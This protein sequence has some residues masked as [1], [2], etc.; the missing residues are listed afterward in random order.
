MKKIII[1]AFILAKFSFLTAQVG[2][3]KASVDGDAILDFPLSNTGIIL[4]MVDALPTA[5][6]ASNGTFLLDK[7]DFR[8][9]MRENDLWVSLSDPGSLT[10]T[11]PNSSAEAGG[12]VIIGAASSPAQGVLVLESASKALVLPKVNDP[13]TSMK[14]PVAG[15]ICYDTVSKTIAVFDGLKWNFWK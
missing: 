14:S 6:A 2:M 15:T 13:V 1:L 4:P 11:M 5:A 8:V 10:G 3:G 9:K 7:T 12:G